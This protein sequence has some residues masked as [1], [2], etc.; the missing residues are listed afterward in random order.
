MKRYKI[1][2]HTQYEYSGPVQLHPHTL[3]LRP[4]EGHELRIESSK[5]EISPAPTLRWRRDV[6]SN[7]VATATFTESTRCLTIKSEIIIQQYDQ[8]PLDFLV[9]DYAVNYPFEYN[10]EDKPLLSPYME[11]ASEESNN[12][13]NDWVDRLWQPGEKIQTF[14]LMLRLNQRINQ[15]L[16][17]GS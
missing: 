3:R 6:E 9:S 8:A 16:P 4:R 10:D 12:A 5:L 17:P 13:L 14:S 11:T 15:T 7:S 1:I 2:H